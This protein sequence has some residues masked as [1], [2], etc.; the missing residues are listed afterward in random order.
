M[1]PERRVRRSSRGQMHPIS[2]HPMS[3]AF[4][5]ALLAGIVVAWEPR[6]W[7]VAV[8]LASVSLISV[9]WAVTARG[10]T[11]PW[12][13]ALVG[14]VAAWGFVQLAFHS[15]VVQSMTMR[16]AIVWL[17]CLAAFVLGSQILRGRRDRDAFLN[18]MLW[19]LTALGACAVLQAYST[20]IRVFGLFAAEPSV[21]GTMFYKNQFAALMELG[22]PIAL[23]RV[24]QGRVLAGGMCYAIMF[25]ATVTSL[26]RA[27]VILV[28]AELLVFLAVMIFGRRLGVKPALAIAGVMAVLIVGAS[29]VAGTDVIRQRME[30]TNPYHMR[31][32]LA[33]STFRMIAARPW[34][35]FGIGTWRAAYPAFATL[36]MAVIAN[37]AHNDWAQWGSEGGIPFLVLLAALTFSVAWPAVESVWGL[38]LL[39]VMAHC[40][41]DYP[42]REPALQLLWF[43]LAGGL[44]RVKAGSSFE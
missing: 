37:E 16:A 25:A 8:A 44:T 1:N 28:L 14:L 17:A 40:Y 43:G 36:D 27:G 11:L 41:V 38:G 31:E 19:A 20:P 23:W 42:M 29:L 7:H 24:M 34:F 2:M 39:A 12:Q 32:Q 15:T 35:G 10:L 5:A 9:V 21:V 6:Y 33:D 4:C 18:A 30:E 26:S 22:A 3:I 13:A